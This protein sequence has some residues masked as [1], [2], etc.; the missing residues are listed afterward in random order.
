MGTGWVCPTDLR[1]VDA[2][3]REAAEHLREHERAIWGEVRTDNLARRSGRDENLP[4]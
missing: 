1:M 4:V 2:R 3:G